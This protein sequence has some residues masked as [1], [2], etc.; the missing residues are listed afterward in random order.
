MPL[1]NPFY[2]KWKSI[3]IAILLPGILFLSWDNLFTYWGVWNFN[4]R[5]VIGVYWFHLPIE[6][7]VWFICIPYA[8]L[9]SYEAA[10]HYIAKDIIGNK[11]KM[12]SL[13]L[14]ISLS[15]IAVFNL[16]RVYTSVTFIGLALFIIFVQWIWKPPFLGRFYLA[17]LFILVPFFIVN[18]I[19]TGTGLE[20]AIVRYDN[21][22]NLS[23]RMGTIP[24][25]DTFYGMLLLMMN[26]S[27]YEWLQ[28]KKAL[29]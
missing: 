7:V 12:I 13:L 6:E 28:T 18:G 15:L 24:V 8:C 2:K 23:I 26:V 17:F 14:V 19:L 27:L 9:F 25:E 10:N 11:Q 1:G 5:Y 3:A 16:A 21:S 22:E 4:P 20:E 29:L